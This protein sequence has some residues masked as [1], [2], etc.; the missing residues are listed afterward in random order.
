MRIYISKLLLLF[1]F[2]KN[3]KIH[4]NKLEIYINIH[5]VCAKL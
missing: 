5:I 1:I 2:I 3:Y 4:N